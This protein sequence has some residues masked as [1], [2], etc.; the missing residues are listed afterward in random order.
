MAEARNRSQII[1]PPMDEKKRTIMKNTEQIS[2]E[3]AR[4]QTRRYS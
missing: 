2:P 1:H 4:G 3:E